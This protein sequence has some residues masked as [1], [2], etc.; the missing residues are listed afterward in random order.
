[1]IFVLFAAAV[2]GMYVGSFFENSWVSGA[3]GW[4]TFFGIFA[5][6]ATAYD[7]SQKGAD[8]AEEERERKWRE[9]NPSREV[10]MKR[11]QSAFEQLFQQRPGDRQLDIDDQHV[12]PNRYPVRRYRPSYEPAPWE[13]YVTATEDEWEHFRLVVHPAAR[14]VGCRIAALGWHDVHNGRQRDLASACRLGTQVSDDPCVKQG[15]RHS[16]KYGQTSELFIIK[17]E[18][19]G[20]TTWIFDHDSIYYAP[21]SAALERR[22]LALTVQTPPPDEG[23]GVERLQKELEVMRSRTAEDAREMRSKTDQI[24]AQFDALRKELPE[25]VKK[26]RRKEQSPEAFAAKLAQLPQYLAAVKSVNDI[27]SNS[28]GLDKDTKD[29][30]LDI[31]DSARS[32]VLAQF[33]RSIADEF[34]EPG[35]RRS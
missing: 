11:E 30:L 25:L 35:G 34:T 32:S 21:I 23:R 24:K 33:K 6:L 10:L 14:L 22:R 26:E 1:M 16:H 17:I 13:L 2:A 28:A 5:T 12:A 31:A 4:T 19:R 18:I 9:E 27:I 7:G 15:Y 20:H 3:I 29:E 8:E